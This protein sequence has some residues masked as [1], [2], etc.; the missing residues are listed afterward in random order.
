MSQSGRKT[1]KKYLINF[2]GTL[3]G[4]QGYS[5][6]SEQIALSLERLGHDVRVVGFNKIPKKNLSRAGQRLKAKTFQQGDIAFVYGFPASFDSIKH[7]KFRIGLT[8]FETDKLPAANTPWSGLRH[9]A[10]QINDCLDLLFVPSKQNAELFRD[11]GVTIPIEILHLGVSQRQFSFIKR[12]RRSTFTFL[13]MATLSLRKNPG[14]V[15]SAFSTLFRDK[16]D[17]TLILKTQSGTLGHIEFKPEMG[18]IRIIDGTYDNVQMNKLFSE[19][20]CFVFPSRGEGFGLPPLEAMAT[21][22][23]TIVADNTGMSEYCDPDY[24]YP[25]PTAF[26]TP[27]LRFPKDWGDVGNW[28]EPDYDMLKRQM[29][30][31]YEHQDQAKRKGMMSAD[32]VK[33]FWNYDLT[34][35]TI[36]D[37]IAKYYNKTVSYNL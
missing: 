9:P 29:L 17:C 28:C 33:N 7:Y 24:C 20:D 34:A 3:G 15:I 27:A 1:E 12:P 16:P 13:Q 35:Q 2:F 19:V 6:S 26:M 36:V 4:G 22:L 18:N 21:G 8:M 10:D 5:G 32:W 11:A 25:V 23:P 14:A 31:V 30:F 37:S